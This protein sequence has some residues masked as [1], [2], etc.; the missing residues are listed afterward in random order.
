MVKSM[1]VT[2]AQDEA[3]VSTF[4]RTPL[5]DGKFNNLRKK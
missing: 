4:F 1:E 2:I 5:I 3:G